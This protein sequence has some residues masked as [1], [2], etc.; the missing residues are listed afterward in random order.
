MLGGRSGN[1]GKCAGPCR[2]PYALLEENKVI[3]SG[4]LLSTRDLCG[5]DFYL[6]L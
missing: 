4:Y 5:L 2:L 1:R 6:D 3:D